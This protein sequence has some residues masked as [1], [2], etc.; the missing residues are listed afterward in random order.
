MAVSEFTQWS[1]T[2]GV[3]ATRLSLTDDLGQEYF[4]ILPREEGRAWRLKRAEAL[5]KIGLAIDMGLKPGEVR[6]R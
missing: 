5:E 1:P 3:E 4:A 2:L 6:W